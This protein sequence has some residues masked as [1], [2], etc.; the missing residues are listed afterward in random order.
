MSFSYS[1]VECFNSC[2][3]KYRLQYIEKLEASDD[4][5]PTN[6]LVE[7]SAVHL[8]I[9]KCSIEEGLNYYKEYFKPYTW[10]ERHDFELEKLKISIQKGIDQIPRGE[11]EYKLLAPEGFIGYIDLLVKIDDGVYDLY[12]MKYSN[13]ISGYR[14]SCQVMLYK[15][16]FERLTGNKVR[17]LYYV[18]IPKSITKLN[19][20]LSNKAEILEELSGMDIHF[21]KVEYDHHQIN[22]FFA[23]KS[24]LEKSTTFPKRYSYKCNWCPFKR[25]CASNGSDLSELNETSKNKLLNKTNE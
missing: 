18:F 17:D 19:E 2:P 5:S 24:L 9:E 10:T 14:K 20:S 11:Y 21:E 3:F 12:D 6:A 8:G 16:Y 4:T 1:K 25:L 15:Y 23:R 13:N 7:G 22:Y